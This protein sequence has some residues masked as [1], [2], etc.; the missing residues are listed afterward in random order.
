ME[1]VSFVLLYLYVP[2]V[3]STSLG[4]AVRLSHTS[5]HSVASQLGLH[6]YGPLNNELLTDVYEFNLHSE[7]HVRLLRH[8]KSHDHVL[9]HIHRRIVTHPHVIWAEHQYMLSRQKREV[10]FND[11]SFPL[12]WHLVSTCTCMYRT[13]Y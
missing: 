1:F 4:W 10:S 2:S 8:Y 11:P 7:D 5:H 3:Y 9:R 6:S 12:Q 13:I